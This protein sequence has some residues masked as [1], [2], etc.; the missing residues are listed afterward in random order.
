MTNN[1]CSLYNVKAEYN[2]NDMSWLDFD[3][4]GQSY[5]C[6]CRSLFADR[7][8]QAGIPKTVSLNCQFDTSD[9]GF[10]T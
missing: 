2:C 1:V 5:P 9:E 8:S 3:K 4:H 10:F 7:H 6:P